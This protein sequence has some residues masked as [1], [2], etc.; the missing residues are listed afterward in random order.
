MTEPLTIAYIAAVPPTLVAGASVFVGLRNSKKA[1]SI[2]VLVN[3]N[4]TAVKAD[5]ALA[6]ERV[7][8]LE[9]L[10]TERK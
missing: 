9:Q 5:L 2:H 1:D 3:S 6:L 8:K 4:L 10:L 7:A